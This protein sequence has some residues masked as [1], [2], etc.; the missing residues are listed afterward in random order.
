MRRPHSTN[1]SVRTTHDNADIRIIL[2]IPARKQP[3]P[4][5]LLGCWRAIKRLLWSGIY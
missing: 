2:L 4:T 5:A 3:R 1:G